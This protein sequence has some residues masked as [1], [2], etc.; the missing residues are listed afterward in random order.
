[1]N[2]YYFTLNYWKK[3]KKNPI[4]KVKLHDGSLSSSRSRSL[5]FGFFT[6]LPEVYLV[7][8]LKT[9]VFN[10]TLWMKKNSMQ[11]Y[12]FFGTI[13]K[14][15]R[16]YHLN[17]IWHEFYKIWPNLGC[18]QLLC[19]IMG[20]KLIS[21]YVHFCKSFNNLT[22]SGHIQFKTYLCQIPLGWKSWFSKSKK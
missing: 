9:I 1:M 13:V 21:C 6:N 17:F 4:L 10:S 16:N 2:T 22:A 7:I 19:G 14:A 20:Q 3:G 18:L 12:E 5:Y 15:K 11:L 8:I